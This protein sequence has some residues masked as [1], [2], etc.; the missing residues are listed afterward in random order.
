M[1]NP[2]AEIPDILSAGNVGTL[3]NSA[4]ERMQDKVALR[5]RDKTTFNWVNL[6]WEKYQLRVRR[7]SFA[8]LECGLKHGDTVAI[9]SNSRLEWVLCDLAIQSI[10]CITIPVYQSNMPN[11]VEYILNHSKVRFVFLEDREQLAKVLEV[12]GKLT[13]LEKIVLFEG[14]VKED[15]RPA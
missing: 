11:E 15:Y 1:M 14:K 5:F 2:E 12:R 6:T 4:A 7:V 9:I 3:F 8:L 10:G 13:H